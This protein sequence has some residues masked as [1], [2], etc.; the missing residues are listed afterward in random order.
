MDDNLNVKKGDPEY[1]IKYRPVFQVQGK[2][3]PNLAGRVAAAFALCYQVF[4]SSDSNFARS[5]LCSGER[6]YAAADTTPSGKLVTAAP[7]DYYPETEWR[8]DMELGAIQ[9]YYATKAEHYLVEA[10]NWAEAYISQGDADVINLYDVGGLAHYELF[11]ALPSASSETSGIPAPMGLITRQRLVDS[12]TDL[13]AEGVANAKKDPFHFTD[14]YNSGDDLVPHAFGF[15]LLANLWKE[16]SSRGNSQ[17]FTPWEQRQ[18]DWIFGANAWGS[19]FVVGG[20]AKDLGKGA[21]LG[22]VFPFCLQHQV[23]NLIGSLNGLPPLLL[24]G[25]VVDGPSLAQNFDDLGTP[26]GARKCPPKGGV[27]PF[28]PFDARGVKYEDNVAAWPSVEP[29]DDYTITGILLFARYVDGM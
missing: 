8:D 21:R 12:I 17:K 23:A 2:I 29:A 3:S 16:M 11:K 25:A 26:D 6:I 7:Y 28:A 4:K 18:F 27:D 24:Y 1:Y 5:C 10:S 20:V 14:Q 22:G 19:S 15:T 13:L 9:M